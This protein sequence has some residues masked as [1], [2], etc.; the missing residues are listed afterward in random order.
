MALTDLDRN[1]A[2]PL[3]APT[4]DRLARAYHDYGAQYSVFSESN[5]APLSLYVPGAIG[6]P[7]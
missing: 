3:A 5:T 7:H 2:Q 4:V 6:W 1:R